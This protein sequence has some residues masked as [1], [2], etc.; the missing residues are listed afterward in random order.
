MSEEMENELLPD[1]EESVV[2]GD[3]VKEIP[4]AQGSV[5]PD[6]GLIMEVPDIPYTLNM[7]KVESAITNIVNGRPVMNRDALGNPESLDYYESILPKLQ[8]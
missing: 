1:L 7:K 8:E 2:A 4:K 5:M 6:L 3:E